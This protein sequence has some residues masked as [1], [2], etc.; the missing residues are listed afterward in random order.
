VQRHVLGFVDGARAARGACVHEIARDLGLPVDR[1]ALAGQRLQRDAMPP[2]LETDPDSFVDQS[3]GVQACCHAGL[4]QHLDR[5][6]LED[7][8]ADASQHVFRAAP[9]QD[10]RVD[11][12][13]VQEL[14]EQ[15]S[16]GPSTD[17]D[18]LG[19]R[20]RRH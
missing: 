16:R 5:A 2:S 3:F 12:G 20:A 19:A 14:P 17:D 9:L 13:T 10:R 4:F 15:Q 18:D 8:G 6:L 11:T 1:D 7:P